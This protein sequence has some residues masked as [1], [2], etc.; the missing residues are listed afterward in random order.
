MNISTYEIFHFL[1]LYYSLL[2]IIIIM[3]GCVLL[4]R[5]YNRE[6]KTHAVQRSSEKG[7]KCM[8]CNMINNDKNLKWKFL[9]FVLFVVVVLFVVLHQFIWQISKKDRILLLVGIL[10]NHI[11]DT[12]KWLPPS[13]REQYNRWWHCFIFHPCFPGNL[14]TLHGIYTI[15]AIFSIH[16]RNA[17]VWGRLAREIP[18]VLWYEWDELQLRDWWP[19]PPSRCCRCRCPVGDETLFMAYYI[20]FMTTVPSR[21]GC[22]TQCCCIHSE[23]GSGR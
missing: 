11:F 22:S 14:S 3:Y 9:P 18:F 17:S 15:F 20:S 2:F 4:S 5:R 23:E 19:V 10:K 7:D 21:P 6:K 16:V 13:D 12:E 1:Y 8:T